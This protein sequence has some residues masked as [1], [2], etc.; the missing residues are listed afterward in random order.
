MV[1]DM[2]RFL[3]L[4]ILAAFG[5]GLAGCKA[6]AGSRASSEM[7]KS[8]SAAA[9]QP[10]PASSPASSPA[11]VDPPDVDKAR[12]VP[13]SRPLVVCFGDSLT[14]GYGADPGQSYPDFLQS[15]LDRDGYRYRVVNE[16]VSGNTTKDGVDR[17][18]GI[19]KMKPAVVVLEFGGNDG[20]RGVKVET[21]RTNL[22][23]MIVGLKAAGAKVVLAGM[24]L[25][26]D[27]GP[28]Y[29]KEF[30]ASYPVLGRKFDLQVIPFLLQDVYGVAG[31]MQADGIHATDRGNE[32]VAKNVA[33]VVEGQLKR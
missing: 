8:F 6:D 14:A 32:V 17:L 27:Y 23:T 4:F 13:D 24:T 25:P 1:G 7:D 31:M 16:G 29:V 33:P 3:Y 22:S 30:T 26:P 2:R 19:V 20:L 12:A 11:N 10:S 18:P 21:T 15:D 9:R 28:D 5:A